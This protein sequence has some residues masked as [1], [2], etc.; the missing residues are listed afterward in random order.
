MLKQLIRTLG[1][2]EFVRLIQEG[3]TIKSVI[4]TVPFYEDLYDHV[5]EYAQ[6]K[7]LNESEQ[8]AFIMLQKLTKSPVTKDALANQLGADQKLLTR[9]LKVGEE[10]NYIISKRA[11]GKEILLSPVFF[12]ENTEIYADLVAKS[13]ASNVQRILNLIK[14]AQGIPLKIIK[15]TKEINGYKLTDE[16]INML[17]RLAHDGAVKPPEIRTSHSGSNYFLFT[18]TPGNIRLNPTKR[19]IYERAMAL[20]AAVRQGQYLA[21]R[22]R[23]RSPYAILNALR[24]VGYLRANT[25]ALE[26]YRNLTVMRVG[27]LVPTT[28]GWFQF[29]LIDSPENKQALDIAINIVQSRET[30]GLEIDENARLAFGK[31]QQYIESIIS[32]ANLRQRENIELTEEQQFEVDNIFLGGV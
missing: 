9:G 30:Q 4:P 2:I 15:E 5:G 12:S 13:G 10:G 27:K 14:N 1:E 22:Y 17:I 23:I 19:E 24:S 28:S 16:E 8:L 21:N 31:N 6:N 26:Q 29:H 32:S 3:E 7:K 25:E 11:R 18:P 20:V